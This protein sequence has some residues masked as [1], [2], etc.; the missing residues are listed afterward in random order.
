MG[1][2]MDQFIGL[3]PVAVQFLK[4]FEAGASEC[5]CCHTLLQPKREEVGTFS[6]MFG[7]DYPLYRHNLT[8]G[9]TA[10]E[11]LQ[12]SPWDCGPMFYL[13]LK[14]SD[15]TQFVWTDEEINS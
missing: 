5:P 8:S 6:G 2:R 15:G 12:C 14:V 1:I 9:L 11:F 10:D 13:G 7:D 3:P 4:E